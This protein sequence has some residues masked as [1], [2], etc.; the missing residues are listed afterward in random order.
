MY[1]YFAIAA[2]GH[3]SGVE[4]GPS[5]VI[6]HI[7]Q[8]AL[9][10]AKINSCMKGCFHIMPRIIPLFHLCV[11][12]LTIAAFGC[13]TNDADSKLPTSLAFHIDRSAAGTP[14]S[15]DDIAATTREM[16]GAWKDAG[17]FQWVTDTSHGMAADNQWGYPDYKLWWDGTVAIKD[18]NHITFKHTGTSDNILL[19]T[20]RV[21]LY[22]L[23]GYNASG[24]QTLRS[25]SLD[26]LK[27]I[28]ALYTCM[29]WADEDPPVDSVMA[30]SFYNHNHDYELS[31]GREVSIDY[32][33]VKFEDIARR[34]DTLHNPGNP[35]FGDI[36]VRAKRSKDDLPFLFRVVPLLM[37]VQQD[38]DDAE[39]VAAVS[40][41]LE[42]IRGFSRDIVDHAYCIRSKDRDGVPFVPM[43]GESLDDF[44]TFTFYD[45]LIGPEAECTAKLSVDLTGYPEK[46][47]SQC[48]EGICET[49]D[50]LV[51]AA[52]YWS[53]PIIRYFHVASASLAIIEGRNDDARALVQGLVRRADD[54]MHD[55][56]GRAGNTEWDGDVAAFLLAS[57]SWG[58]PLT[59]E[60]AQL[61]SRSLRRAAA[62]YRS[63]GLWNLWDDAVADGEYDYIPGREYPAA[64]D[65]QTTVL[66]PA[67]FA[68]V[69]EYCE[70]PFK[71][72]AGESFIDC[73]VVLNP[74]QWGK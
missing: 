15:A 64:D 62:H 2:S 56:H 48:G 28:K 8:D 63:F 23:A 67:E 37:R 59:A 26:Y 5:V 73:S 42:Y 55:D 60:E 12:A 22:T 33:P 9:Y 14:L 35:T 70:S 6:L 44:A 51:G 53:L 32:S 47:P 7:F 31:G 25:I 29:R 52:H 58:L 54:M 40:E 66:R 13:S 50:A 21:L 19:R 41:T 20:A 57:A 17:Y 24:D 27:G 46:T 69:L 38:S 43:Y 61:V 45:A 71:D 36:W 74:A 65:G 1:V 68:A 34:H 39:M 72:P 4:N 3:A 11:A 49:Y 18:G 10:W 30:R 16:T